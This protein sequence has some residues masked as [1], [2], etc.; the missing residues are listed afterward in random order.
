MD[1]IDYGGSEQLGVWITPEGYQEFKKYDLYAK[2]EYSVTDMASLVLTKAAQGEQ[3]R[4]QAR[5]EGWSQ[6]WL[7]AKD[8]RK[9]KGKRKR[10]PAGDAGAPEPQRRATT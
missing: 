8:E 9:G 1:K 5:I 10:N 4:R 3:S 6:G 2:G 7:A